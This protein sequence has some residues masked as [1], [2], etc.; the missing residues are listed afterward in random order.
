MKYIKKCLIESIKCHHND[1]ANY[2]L[3]QYLL[4]EKDISNDIMINSLKYH[5]LNFEQNDLITESSF[6]YLCKYD[7]YMLVKSI[8]KEMDI[9]VNTK[10]IHITLIWFNYY[11]EL[12]KIYDQ[13]FEWRLKSYAWI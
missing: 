11:L 3:N 2:I 9:D 5:N 8:L 13:L 4:K 10:I 1:I 6:Y 12:N 7:H